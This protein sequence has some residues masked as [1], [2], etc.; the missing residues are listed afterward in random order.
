MKNTINNIFDIL[1]SG[2]SLLH[3]RQKHRHFGGF[4]VVMILLYNVWVPLIAMEESQGPISTSWFDNV[5]IGGHDSVAYHAPEAIAN[6]K[7][8]K[9][10]KTW[11]HEWRGA[12]WRFVSEQNYQAFKTNPEKYRPAYGGFCANALSLGEG[13]VRTNGTH[14]EIWEDHL[15]LFYSAKGRNRWTERDYR[16][17]RQQADR[18]WKKITGFED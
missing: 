3:R 17:Y 1:V 4:F 9:G 13:L 7:E 18:A 5:A 8:S 10:Q 16:Q 15:Y 11:V 14:W 12:T 2:R 6:H